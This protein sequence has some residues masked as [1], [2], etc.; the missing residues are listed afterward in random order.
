[1]TSLFSAR[2]RAEEFA[3]VVDAGSADKAVPDADIAEFMGIVAALRMHEATPRPEFTGDLR[4]RLMSEAQVALTPQNAMLELPVLRR[5]LRERRLVAAACAVV[6]VGGTTTMAAAAQ[7]SLPGEALY[8][9]K[10]GIERVEASLSMSDAGK[11]QDLLSQA[12]ARLAEVNGLLISD[13]VQSDPQVPSTLVDFSTQAD[14]GSALLLESFEQTG[15]P[16]SVSTVR[17]FATG[18]IVALEAFAD[19]VPADAQDELAAAA[20]TLRDIDEQATSLCDTCLPD[21]P[22]VEVPNM[23]AARAEVNRALQTVVLSKLD[24]SHPVVV[25]RGVVE[26]SPGR[27]QAKRPDTVPDK[28]QSQRPATGRAQAPSGQPAGSDPSLPAAPP[29]AGS[30]GPVAGGNP[31]VG[32]IPGIPPVVPAPSPSAPADAKEVPNKPEDVLGGAMETLLPEA[33]TQIL[34]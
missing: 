8:P 22:A 32:N 26:Q 2:R 5:G 3:T 20:S 33:D 1:M 29:L 16:A 18:A 17:S 11:G 6:L 30:D 9:I 28:S 10:R 7:S 25:P 23:M 24:N 13:S 4:N 34:P 21:V 27:R 12:E 14:E 31:R 15:D 19:A